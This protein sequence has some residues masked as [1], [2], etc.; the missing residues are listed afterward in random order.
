MKPH[1]QAVREAQAWNRVLLAIKGR[2]LAEG[3]DT[4]SLDVANRNPNLQRLFQLEAIADFLEGKTAEQPE[5]TPTAQPAKVEAKPSK[6][7]ASAP[8]A[9]APAGG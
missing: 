6:T 8:P 5:A 2:A 4:S 3:K 1:T 7:G 9:K